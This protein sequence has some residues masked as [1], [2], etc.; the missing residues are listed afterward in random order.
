MASESTMANSR[1][2]INTREH[3]L[4]LILLGV[5]FGTVIWS[6]ILP[7][8]RQTWALEV[9]PVVIG[10][11]VLMA[12]YRRFRFT[13]LPYVSIFLAGVLI[14]IGGH[15]T[16]ARVPIGNWAKDAFD[17]SRNHYDRIG[18]FMQGV[19][20][21]L[22]LREMVLRR[23]GVRRGLWLFLL[24][25]ASS[26]AI[27]ALFE[28]IEWFVAVAIGDGSQAYLSTQGDEWDAHWD[29]LLAFIGAMGV[30]LLLAGVQDRQLRGR[31]LALDR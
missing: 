6:G 4:N 25:T 1:S 24:V 30:Q 17:L 28:F 3:Q 21:A 18:H 7:Y 26:L 13:R 19:F 2:D 12:T 9:T 8:D 5:L 11:G 16:F 23:S 14:C 29:M 20:S 10:V 31:G 22:I 27:S 15:W